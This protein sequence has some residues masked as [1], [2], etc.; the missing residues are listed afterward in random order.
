M[1]FVLYAVSKFLL[2][3]RVIMSASMHIDMSKLNF[4]LFIGMVKQVDCCTGNGSESVR[5]LEPLGDPD[6]GAFEPWSAACPVPVRRDPK[7]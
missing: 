1:K 2:C 4:F 5:P 7:T 6:T 3:I